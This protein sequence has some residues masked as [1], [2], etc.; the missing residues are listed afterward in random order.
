MERALVT[1]TRLDKLPLTQSSVWQTYYYKFFKNVGSTKQKI[2]DSKKALTISY[3]E[4]N[5]GN[6]IKIP[7]K[8][9]QNLVNFNWLVRNAWIEVLQ[10][11]LKRYDTKNV[12]IL[13][14]NITQKTDG[15]YKNRV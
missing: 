8:D 1:F 7:A 15:P 11:P 3:L 2:K 10:L 9:H 4:G 6:K 13:H 5:Y 14:K 12:W